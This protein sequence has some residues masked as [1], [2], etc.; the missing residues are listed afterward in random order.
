MVSFQRQQ[1]KIDLLVLW[2]RI[3]R[4][5]LVMDNMDNKRFDRTEE[6]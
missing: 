2:S 3:M 6:K 4:R 1:I 5:R